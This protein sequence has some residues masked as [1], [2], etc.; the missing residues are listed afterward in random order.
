MSTI[1]I[2]INIK[3]L[4]LIILSDFRL[5]RNVQ[6]RPARHRTALAQSSMRIRAVC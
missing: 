3:N 5:M 4:M 2:Q 1:F 6:K